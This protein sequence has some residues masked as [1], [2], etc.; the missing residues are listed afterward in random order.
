[1]LLYICLDDSLKSSLFFH[2]KNI[3]MTF[4]YLLYWERSSCEQQN[5]VHLQK[6]H[7]KH[8]PS[9]D[10]NLKIINYWRKHFIFFWVGKI[11][12]NFRSLLLMC[13]NCV[14]KWN[15][16]ICALLDRKVSKKRKSCF[17][18]V[19]IYWKTWQPNECYW[20]SAL[21]CFDI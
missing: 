3:F 4:L 10:S 2:W 5:E 12:I 7:D 9:R 21:C 6:V 8:Y 13:H 19:I 15:K 14:L 20:H 17:F 1:L 18:Q 11:Y 16:C